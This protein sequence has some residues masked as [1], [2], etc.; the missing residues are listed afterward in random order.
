MAVNLSFIGGAGWQFLDDSGTPLSGGKIYT[1][2]A[3]TTTPQTTF[4]SRS[5]LVANANP[6]ILDAAGRTPEQI[7]ATEGLLYKYVVADSNDVVIRTWDNIGGSVVASDLA[8]DLANTTDNSKGDALIGFKQ[9]NASGFLLNAVA[10]TVNNKLQEIVSIKDFGAVGDGVTDDTIALQNALNT[11][12]DIRFVDGN[13]LITTTLLVSSSNQK[14]YLDK[15]AV[16]QHGVN[17]QTAIRITGSNVLFT[18]G[19]IVSTGA[20]NSA[21]IPIGF[22]VIELTGAD[23]TVDGVYLDKTPKFGVSILNGGCSVRNCYIDSKIPEQENFPSG[24]ST[25]L[26]G[27]FIG[28]QTGSVNQIIIESNTILN[29]I[30]GILEG[31]SLVSVVKSALIQN[32]AFRN[33][34]DHGIYFSNAAGMSASVLGNSFLNCCSSIDLT[35]NNFV[36]ANNYVDYFGTTARRARGGIGLRESSNSIISN[37]YVRAVGDGQ[38][39][40]GIQNI[41]PVD[42][43][44]NVIQG[45]TIINTEGL[46]CFAIRIRDFTGNDIS[47]NVISNNTIKIAKPINFQSVIQ[48]QGP[49]ST[50]NYI[51]GNVIDFNL[52]DK[53]CL[54]IWPIGGKAIITDNKITVNGSAT[55]S[56]TADIITPGS[57]SVVQNNIIIGGSGQGTNYTLRVINA[58][59]TTNTIIKSNL[60]NFDDSV[61]TVSEFIRSGGSTQLTNLFNQ[62]TKNAIAGSLT[63]ASGT[64]SVAVTGT[65]SSSGV[66]L[67]PT[68]TAAANLIHTNGYSIS[69][70]AGGFT[71]TLGTGTAAAN[72]N[73]IWVML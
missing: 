7:W 17:D 20:Y 2:A 73:F 40:I 66:V 35:G 45:N 57:N 61:F 28:N 14:V 49:V 69:A 53:S 42:L 58:A 16:I 36:V 71:V 11:G 46:Q 19:K 18:G 33:C 34:Y 63:I 5:G 32:N 44:N 23:V 8:Q 13:Y 31:K 60:I 6:I 25:Q 39:L 30:S 59:S 9:S 37:N 24:F 68:N 3:G 21:V 50:K 41:D 56:R 47:E 38:P 70:S 64:S 29:S 65:Q 12:K 22:A 43:K 55:V 26:G 52:D 51:Q 62:L 27:I 1:Y 54:A 10:R 72:A 67:I 48:I 4:T 15:N